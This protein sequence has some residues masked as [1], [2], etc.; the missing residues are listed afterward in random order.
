MAATAKRRVKRKIVLELRPDSSAT[1]A[2]ML[3]YGYKPVLELNVTVSALTHTDA[4]SL[5]YAPAETVRAPILLRI[6]RERAPCSR[7]C[8]INGQIFRWCRNDLLSNS[9]VR[10]LASSRANPCPQCWP[11]PPSKRVW[12]SSIMHFDWRPMNSTHAYSSGV[13]Q[14]AAST[15]TRVDITQTVLTWATYNIPQQQ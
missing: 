11:A 15:R 13:V 6:A 10:T 12:S 9:A 7:F 1:R 8:A 2:T 14:T 3:Q 5:C 4:A